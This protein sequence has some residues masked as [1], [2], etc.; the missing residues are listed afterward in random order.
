MS[1]ADVQSAISEAELYVPAND[2]NESAQSAFDRNDMGNARRFAFTYR[3]CLAFREGQRDWLNWNKKIWEPISINRV[4]QL[5]ERT[6]D[7]IG[8]EARATEDGASRD[9]LLRHALQSGQIGRLHAIEELARGHLSV[10]E[11]SWDNAPYLLPVTN[12]TLDLRTGRLG[13]HRV[14]DRLTAIVDLEYDEAAQCP[15]WNRFVNDVTSNNRELARFL[16]CVVG[17]TLTGTTQEQVIFILFGPGAN[18][19]TTF[20]EVVRSLLGT[21]ARQTPNATFSARN[22]DGIRDDLARLS[23]ARFVTSTELESGHQL[24]EVLVKQLTGGDPVTAR[25]L[26]KNLFEYVPQFKIFLPVNHLPKIRNSDQGIWRRIKIIP[27]KIQI[28][29][30]ILNCSMKLIF[31]E[32]VWPISKMNSIT[33]HFNTNILF[34][35]FNF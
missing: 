12:G 29:C 14:E 20:L 3:N 16:Q 17:Y 1:I 5:A 32:I 15:N 25:A 6:V 19:K 18:G 26:Y 33:K 4:R 22:Q 30:I 9:A 2:E 27:F 31:I 10:D 35:Y 8:A 34:V 11:S 7:A 21:Y 23:G 24:S 28:N 13:P